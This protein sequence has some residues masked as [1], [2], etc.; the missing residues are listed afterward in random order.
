MQGE[1]PWSE[2][3]C[4]VRHHLAQEKVQKAKRVN[5]LL[6]W[7]PYHTQA[8]HLARLRPEFHQVL[9]QPGEA[10]LVRFGERILKVQLAFL[11]HRDA[12]AMRT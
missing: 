2:Y 9:H 10:L 1:C 12:G 4:R 11:P 7:A 3:P 8:T 6:R 5:G